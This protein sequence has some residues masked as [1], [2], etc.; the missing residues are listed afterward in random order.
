[1]NRDIEIIIIGILRF[2]QL[3]RLQVEILYLYLFSE[4]YSQK[5]S[6]TIV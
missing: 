6:P 3:K 2:F 5:Y 1:M 4:F